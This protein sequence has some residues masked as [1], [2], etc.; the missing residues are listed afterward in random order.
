VGLC[1][2]VERRI[3]TKERENLSLVQRRERRG[4]EVYL[5]ADKKEV[6]LTIKVTIDGTSVFCGKER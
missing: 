2:K 3:C 6:Y 4:K 1:N 5:E